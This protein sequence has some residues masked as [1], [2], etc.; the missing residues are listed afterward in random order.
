MATITLKAAQLVSFLETLK[1]QQA[2]DSSV[3]N[4]L[5]FEL[6]SQTTTPGKSDEVRVYAKSLSGTGSR[7]YLGTT[8]KNA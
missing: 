4:M 3:S 5:E 6:V 7:H 8:G 2:N 1:D